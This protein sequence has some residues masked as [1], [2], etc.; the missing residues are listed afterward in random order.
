M[1][2]QVIKTK[3]ADMKVKI[4]LAPIVLLLMAC[5]VLATPTPTDSGITGKVSVGPMCP[6]IIEGQ[7]CPDRPL[8]ATLIV[9][10]PDGKKIVQ[11]QTDAKGIFKVPLAPGDYI[12]HPEPPQGKPLPFASDQPFTVLPGEFTRLNVQ[13]DSGIR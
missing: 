6:V 9:N 2:L 5:S 3:E 11:F 13:Y 7:E 12:L 1:S 4:L 10:S 8:Q